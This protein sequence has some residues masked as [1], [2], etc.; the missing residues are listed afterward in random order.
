MSNGVGCS[1]GHRIFNLVSS[2]GLGD[3]ISGVIVCPDAV[4]MSDIKRSMDT[5]TLLIRLT[6]CVLYPARRITCIM[7]SSPF[8]GKPP[9]ADGVV[10]VIP[11]ID[12]FSYRQ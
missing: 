8:L 10:T 9:S 2:L 11:N 5:R 3:R 12:T 7:K 4:S 1:F 6:S